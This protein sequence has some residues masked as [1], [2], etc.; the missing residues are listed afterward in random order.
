MKKVLWLLPLCILLY[1]CPFESTVALEPKPVEPVDS[2]LCGYWYGIVKDG[3]DFF[4]IEALDI[5][6]QSDSVYAI[7][8]YGKAIKGDIILPDTA[9]FTGYTSWIGD[10]QYMNVVADILLEEPRRKGRTPELK[11]QRVYYVAGIASKQD[12]LTVKTITETF[13]I[14]KNFGSPEA[15]KQAIL[16]LTGNDKA[17]YDEQYSLSYRKIPKPQP[18]RSF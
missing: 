6:R 1:A 8:R 15:F 5:S 14:K 4:G 9:Y 16:Q 3:S 12:T 13:S 7:T 11:K 18:A 17:L 10:K 2:S